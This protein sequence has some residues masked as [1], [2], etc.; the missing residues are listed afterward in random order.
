MD[1]NIYYIWLSEHIHGNDIDMKGAELIFRRASECRISLINIESEE[2]PDSLRV[3]EKPPLVLYCI[4]ELSLLR[5]KSVAVVGTR[6]ASSYGRWAA[7]EIGKLLALNSVAH[8]SGM[9]EGIDSAGH[10]A[11][12][13]AN[14]K[15]IAVLGTGVD[16]CFP[17]SSADVYAALKKRGLIVSEYK[18][19]TSGYPSNF[20]KRNRIISALAE[21][22]I[23]VEGALKSGSLITARLAL[24]Q[25]KEIYAVPGNINQPGS[26]GPNSLIEDGAVPIVNPAQIARS[27]GLARSG[28]AADPSGLIG[29]EKAV[30]QLIREAGTLQADDIVRILNA[31]PDEI[32]AAITVLELKGFLKNDCGLISL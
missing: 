31:S 13:E 4:G 30:Y 16:I 9:A 21:K 10:R 15:S 25:G 14:G 18:P 5:E 29:M 3:I 11:V 26:I 6:R 7:G 2:Y 12:L 28:A 24:D 22:L 32:A 19:G 20:P 27:L 8:V 1:K 23:V 17:K